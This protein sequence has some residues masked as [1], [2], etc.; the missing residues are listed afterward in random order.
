MFHTRQVCLVI[1]KTL[2]RPRV[3]QALF[4]SLCAI[5]LGFSLSWQ[6]L[7][8]LFPLL[9]ISEIVLLVGSKSNALPF[10]SEEI[11]PWKS[12]RVADGF[13]YVGRTALPISS[14]PVAI[15][16]HQNDYVTL[17]LPQNTIS[18]KIPVVRFSP[19]YFPAVKAFIR[20]RLPDTTM[21]IL[22][23]EGPSAPAIKKAS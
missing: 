11:S 13:L 1:L 9:L 3:V 10:S 12:L 22:A 16:A 7:W 4:L 23:A 2:A 6:F 17:Q 15:L 19:V 5:L 14:V 21:H 20:L 18:G 8:L